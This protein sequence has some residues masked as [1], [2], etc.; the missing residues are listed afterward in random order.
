M[1]FNEQ[2]NRKGDK[3]NIKKY[4]VS[5]VIWLTGLP[6][7]GKSTLSKKLLKFFPK[8]EVLDG[9]TVLLN[10]LRPSDRK[11][12][13]RI[14]HAERV[15]YL[16]KLLLKHKIPV[17][18]AVI[19]PYFESRNIA[20]KIIGTKDFIEIYIK[21]SLETCEKR[22]VKGMYKQ[23]RAGNL[24]NFTGVN[25]PYDIPEKPNL[26]VDTENNSID[27]CVDSILNYLKLKNY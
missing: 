21:C 8:M 6:C 13:S 14:L 22:D 9:D 23:A 10:S 19:S 25:A 27:D 16:A 18:A 15:A 20:R 5:F 1:I 24:E 17:C 12:E 7:S 11:K 2:S 26:I 4:F 3:Y